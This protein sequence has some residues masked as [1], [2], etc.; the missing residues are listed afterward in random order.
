MY[1]V[2]FLPAPVV[3]GHFQFVVAAQKHHGGMRGQPRRL[4]LHLLLHL[5]KNRTT[6]WVNGSGK[7]KIHPQHQA[8][9]IGTAQQPLRRI[10]PSAPKANGVG[11][12]ARQFF[13]ALL[14][15]GILL[16]Q[17]GAL[18]RVG[19]PVLSADGINA[20]TKPTLAVD[21]QRKR[22]F[23]RLLQSHRAFSGPNRCRIHQMLGARWPVYG[24]ELPLHVDPLRQRAQSAARLP[25][26][27]QGPILE[28]NGA[29]KFSLVRN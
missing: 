10:A 5:L 22:M 12:G 21:H 23:R 9:R 4:A 18:R 26:L 1:A 13:Q 20:R 14:Q 11:A 29:G 25:G 17:G 16:A 2:L 6:H 27:P 24:P 7:G 28:R 3:P 19:R 8:Q 15:D